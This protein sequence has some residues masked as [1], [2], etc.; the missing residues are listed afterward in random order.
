M[1][2]LLIV[3]WLTFVWVLLWGG[4]TLGNVLAGA[5]IATVLVLLFPLGPDRGGGVHPVAVLRFGLFFAWAL[6]VAT[7]TVVVTL[8]R[9]RLALEQG[10]VAVPMRATSPVVVAFVANSISLTPG[11]LTV[12]VRPRTYGIDAGPD[13]TEAPVLYVHCLVVGDPDTV[14]ADARHVEELAVRAFGTVHDRAALEQE[15]TR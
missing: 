8:L 3:L 2:R 5:G 9:P 13:D 10:I 14:R 7:W 1:N 4:L 15:A 6:V 11:T 12:D